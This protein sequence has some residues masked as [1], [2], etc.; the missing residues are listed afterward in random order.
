M[1]RVWWRKR[2]PLDYMTGQ[3]GPTAR[4]TGVGCPPIPREPS[5]VDFINPSESAQ[6]LS[7]F[8]PAKPDCP[9]SSGGPSATQR[10]KPDRTALF[11]TTNGGPSALP[12]INCPDLCP[13]FPIRTLIRDHCSAK[14]P[15]HQDIV[16]NDEIES[17]KH[18]HSIS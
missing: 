9:L 7:L 3:L 17:N 11:L 14:I 8:C 2:K 6:F 15:M 1:A 13:L 4:P 18:D 16:S 5:Y 12:K 10:F